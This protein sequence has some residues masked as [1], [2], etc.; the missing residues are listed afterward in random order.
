MKDPQRYSAPMYLAA[1]VLCFGLSVFLL[2]PLLMD[3][4]PSASIE[5]M[6]GTEIGVFIF[7][8]LCAVF[9]LALTVYYA[10]WVVADERGVRLYKLWTSIDLSWED[11]RCVG[12]FEVHG[13]RGNS[14]PMLLISPLETPW[15]SRIVCFND[16]RMRGYF[17]HDGARSLCLPDNEALRAVIQRY[18]PLPRTPMGGFDTRKGR[19]KLQR[20]YVLYEP[21]KRGDGGDGMDAEG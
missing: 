14:L 6:S 11:V 8:L 1:F 3:R 5:A 20:I 10:G 18:C 16:Q 4:R 21:P 2:V 17:R 19:E 12:A 13:R 7:M 9:M 15:E